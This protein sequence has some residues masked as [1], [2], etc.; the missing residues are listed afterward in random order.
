MRLG[1][2][3]LETKRIGSR[4][5]YPPVPVGVALKSEGRPGRYLAWAHPSENNCIRNEAR[6]QIMSFMREHTLILH[7]AAFDLDVLET[8]FS[9]RWPSEHHDTL[10]MAFLEDPDSYSLA[11]KPL[12]QR[13]LDEP[14]TEQDAVRDYCTAQAKAGNPRFKGAT[15]KTFG[16]Y[17]SECPG[18]LIGRYAI[19]DVDRTWRLFRFFKERT[20]KGEMVA[21]YERER[22][23]TQVLIKI[24]R[25]GMP[26]AVK[27][28]KAD[29]GKYGFIKAEIETR[30]LTKMKVPKSQHHDIIH[31]YDEQD[32][33]KWGGKT[34]AERLVSSGL[35]DHLP[36]TEK[37]NDSVSAESLKTVMP[38]KLAAEFE[39]RSQIQTCL[40]TF[41]GPWLRQ[42]QETGKFF[43][44]YN[45][46]RSGDEWGKS[47]GA[48]TG[49][50]SMSPNLQNVIRSDKD[51]RVPILRDYLVCGHDYMYLGQRDYS[52]QEL[53]ILAHYENGPFLASYLQDPTQDAHE[54]V[55]SLIRA[56][57]GKDV[58]RR[59]VK[60][61]NFG[62]IY[63]Q[64]LKTT[65]EKMGVEMDVAREL[66]A[67]HSASLPGVPVL[68]KAL[69]KRATDNLPIF[70]FG[71][72]RYF[73]E[74]PSF[75]N[76]RWM[77]WS[78][79]LINRLIQGSAADIT[80]QSLINY[81]AM[82]ISN[83]NPVLLSIHDEAIFG[84][85]GD[86]AKVHKAMAEA[87]A[88]IPNMKVPM[89]SDGKLGVSSWYRMQKYDFQTSAKKDKLG[90]RVLG[91]GSSRISR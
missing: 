4:P 24:E 77:D 54:L 45:Q 70:T 86:P 29:I 88:D 67:A 65:A 87:M 26:V 27:R 10:I 43:A 17:I 37:G 61:M 89:L 11:L 40:N 47:V 2:L 32:H 15:A 35:V 80:K 1:V 55:R 83:E 81:D 6:R 30:L 75:A 44:R 16:A 18:N 69:K 39:V 53:R 36:Q 46:V 19:G 57:T 84:I 22:R 7:N 12:A 34:F 66:R 3:D 72:R 73:C 9:I 38:V 33:F 60:D 20:L 90:S 48:G 8:H 59:P 50:L 23:L 21:A 68:I 58:P 82:G 52:Q 41:M 91:R 28:L 13:Y 56:T 74:R 85:N 62:L 76:G 5:D 31:D 14:P 25:R 51:D 79:K 78:Y 63:G 71:G 64:G 49:R 42:A